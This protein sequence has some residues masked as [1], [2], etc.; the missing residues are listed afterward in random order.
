VKKFVFLAKLFITLHDLK[1]ADYNNDKLM[2]YLDQY[3]IPFKNL[4][5]G[6]HRYVFE[7]ND[8]F[9]EQFPY[10]EIKKGNLF[11]QVDLEVNPNSLY[12]N[13][14]INGTVEVQCD[15]CL[16]YF[17][18][19]VDYKNHLLVKFS[20]HTS[21]I[22]DIDDQMFLDKEE[23]RINVAKHIYDYIHLSLPMK[24][25]H[26]LDQEGNPTCDPQML[27]KLEELKPKEHTEPDPRW[28]GLKELLDSMN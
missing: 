22:L 28:S 10:S 17:D 9:F 26:P 4:E 16:G 8:K 15:R 19:P 24:K 23:G 6:Q 12:L 5:Q 3:I 25:V 27:Q 1:L 20:D 13:F 21:N 2:P 11:V 18:Y 7:V 14:E